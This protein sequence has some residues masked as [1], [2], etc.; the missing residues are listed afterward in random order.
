MKISVRE[1]TRRMARSSAGLLLAAL[2]SLTIALFFA[3]GRLVP[4]SVVSW[5]DLGC[6]GPRQEGTINPSFPEFMGITA[7]GRAYMVEIART[8]DAEGNSRNG[9]ALFDLRTNEKL[10]NVESEA[11]FLWTL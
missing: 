7:C 5:E 4:E 10:G 9:T 3:T 8:P 1:L 6:R 2:G 11:H